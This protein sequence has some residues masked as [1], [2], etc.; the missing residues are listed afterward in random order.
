[1]M[2][3]LTKTDELSWLSWIMLYDRFIF[4]CKS[5]G[6]EIYTLLERKPICDKCT[7]KGISC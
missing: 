7:A 1:M 6:D 2:R 4:N 3:G 5:C